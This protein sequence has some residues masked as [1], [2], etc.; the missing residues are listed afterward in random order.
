MRPP[1]P[2]AVLAVLLAS[3]T[4]PRADDRFDACVE[5]ADGVMPTMGECGNEWVE[6]E[7]ETLNAAWKHLMGLDLSSEQ[8]RT[9]LDE[10][11]AWLGY[12]DKA[13]LVYEDD[14]NF[15]QNG[16]YLFF[17]N[18][19]AELIAKRVEDLKAYADAIDPP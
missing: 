16:R 6:R 9:F 15:G 1:P 4:L 2:V 11:R 18:C 13:C 12:R 3:A 7:D 8:K 10:Q 17:P 14:E 5:A 19:R